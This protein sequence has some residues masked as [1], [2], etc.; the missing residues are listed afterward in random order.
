MNRLSLLLAGILLSI[1]LISCNEDV[2]YE[3]LLKAESNSISNFIKTNVIQVTTQQPTD[4]EWASNPNL[5]YRTSDNIYL[6]ID[7]VGDKTVTLKAN[8]YVVLTMEKR[9]LSGIVVA[10][11]T[12]Q[13]LSFNFV[14]PGST[15]S[16]YFYHSKGFVEA[17]EIIAHHQASAR[18]IIPS[19]IA[20]YTDMNS[21][22]PYL[23]VIK[24]LNIPD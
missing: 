24:R 13:P 9:E 4:E 6:R 20:N 5:W 12:K 14:T 11:Y 19:R 17:M 3:D 7:E 18:F 10:D 22:T 1:V 15:G 2:N 23:Y 8:D 16:T 21:V